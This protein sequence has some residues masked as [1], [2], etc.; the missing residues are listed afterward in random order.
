MLLKLSISN[1]AIIRELVFEPSAKLNIIT[2][3]TGAG[4][5]IIL[6]ALGL[7]LGSRADISTK[8]DWGK[9]CV[10]EGVFALDEK[11]F[12]PLFNSLGL[13][14]EKETIIRREIT[15]AGK[16]RSFINDTPVN[17]SQIKAI[18]ESLVNVHSQNDNTL[19]VEREFQFGVLDGF[20]GLHNALETYR[21]HLKEYRNQCKLLSELEI[22]QQALLKEKDYLQYLVT[23][24]ETA[25][26]VTGEEQTL[27]SE[28]NLLNNAEQIGAVA[29]LTQLSLIDNEQS[30]VDTLNVLKQQMKS[31]SQASPLAAELLKR[32]ESVVIELKDIAREAVEL[33]DAAQPDGQRLE[34]VN[35]RLALI[36]NMKRKHGVNDIDELL[37]E[38][39]SVSDKLLTIDNIDHTI[40][41]LQTEIA[42]SEKRLGLLAGDLHKKRQASTKA[43]ETEVK[44]LLKQLEMPKADIKFDLNEKQNF[45][46]F[47]TS[48]LN[49]LF[50]ANVGMPLQSMS[51]VASGGELSRLALCFRSLE[52]EQSE[53]GTLVFDEIDTGVSGKV[54]DTIG[55]MYE[56]LAQRHQVIAITHLPQVAGYG[57]TH[58][59]IGKR[60]EDNKTVSYLQLLSASDRVNELAK[61]LSGNEATEVA[62]QNAMELLKN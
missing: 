49:I 31:V 26:L 29:D 23:E 10:V 48:E 9:K 14:Y 18:T 32:I 44:N 45:D 34:E 36:Q 28:L 19:L 50:T 5:S 55:A 25:A 47:G 62:K 39:Q 61:M 46:D 40:Q 60:E 24:F 12:L 41:A 22:K 33:K 54:A 21:K 57:S 20:S 11:L 4:K 7:I 38:F 15:D 35:E 59:M 56:Q 43:I 2:G 17:L 30:I 37:N 53:I 6:D 8:S 13:D 1:F 58:F 27:E 51:K 16:S 3:E 52:A 42:Q